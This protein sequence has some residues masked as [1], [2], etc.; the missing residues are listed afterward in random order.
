MLSFVTFKLMDEN[1]QIHI[2]QKPWY[3]QV[4][5]QMQIYKQ[6]SCSTISELKGSSPNSFRVL[7]SEGMYGDTSR[8]GEN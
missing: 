4:H 3:S 5:H 6:E 2:D 1:L 8:E 7:M